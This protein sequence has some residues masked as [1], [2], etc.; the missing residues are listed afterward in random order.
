MKW[1]DRFHQS[2]I[3]P[4]IVWG[5]A[6]L[7]G[8]YTFLLQ[9]SP[10]VMIP[11]LMQVY[12][13]DVVEIGVLTSSF[14]YTYIILQI[15]AGITIDLWGPRRVL[16]TCFL[17]CSL[18]VGWFAFSHQFWEGQMSR[19]LM[20]LTTAPA[21]VSVF[22][23]ASRW[24]KPHLFTLLV[25]LTEFSALAG[26]VL[27][28]G[29]LAFSVVKMGWRET[30][31]LVAVIGLVLTFLALFFIHDYPDHDQPL[32]NGLTFKETLKKTGRSLATVLSI[33]QIW[34]NGIYGGLIFGLFP[35]FAALWGVPYISY[36]Y[37]LPVDEAALVASMFFL[38]ACIGTLT[39]GG[40]SVYI[41]KR[42][43]IMLTA[44]FITL[45]FS[46]SIIY[47][48]NVSLT[49]MYILVLLM[50]FFS[51]SYALC[52]ALAS[53]Y[54]SKDKKGVA[55]GFTNMLCIAFGAPILQPLIG[56]LLKYHTIHA[57]QA[58][59]GV[60]DLPDYQIALSP[61]PICLFLAFLLAFFVRERSP[62]EEPQSE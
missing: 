23:L 11:Q 41:K 53:S 3:R 38:G 21:I 42:K 55:M 6:A 61:L 15:P 54:V 28:E 24:F 9:G 18:A 10:S 45:L 30:M 59:I 50:G 5:L 44:S 46:L 31:V 43:P 29:G 1:L 35:A 34:M 36:R 4:W 56:Y 40:L 62:E 51:S 26:G 12:Q 27:G 39:L 25:A 60:Y 52:F 20:G 22:C 19:M 49:L 8:L 33:R 17:F 37:E 48:P 13:I 32:H 14:F 7:L 16:K 58:H 47:V 57:P 2:K